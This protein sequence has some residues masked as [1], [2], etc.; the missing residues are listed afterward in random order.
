M[1]EK[2]TRQDIDP[3]SRN[4]SCPVL[5]EHTDNTTEYLDDAQPTL[6][7]LRVWAHDVAQSAPTLLRLYYAAESAVPS[8]EFE[9][10]PGGSSKVTF[11]RNFIDVGFSSVV[12]DLDLVV[13]P[14]TTARIHLS[15]H[16]QLSA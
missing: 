16:D 9:S 15:S 13:Q 8:Y 14:S 12:S 3:V 6:R 4:L 11:F 10:R 2:Y 1:S 5:G 7:Y